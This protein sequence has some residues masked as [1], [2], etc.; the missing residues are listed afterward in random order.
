MEQVDQNIAR[1]F[2]TGGWDSTFRLLQL[3]L[4]QKKKVQ[5]YYLIDEDRLSTG[6]ELRTMKI[7]KKHLFEKYP[8]TKGLML[9]TVFKAVYDIQPNQDLT[10]KY[11][12]ILEHD[13]IGT[14]YEWL[15]RF[16][17]EAGIEGV[18]LGIEK[19]EQTGA[20]KVLGAFLVQSGTKEDSYYKFNEEFS[21]TDE[22]GL[23]K[24]YNFPLFNIAKIDMQNIA[25]NEGFEDLL[26]LTWFCHTPRNNRPC[27]VCTP[28]VL[29]IEEGL[30]R[31]IPLSSR[32]RYYRRDRTR[33]KQFLTKWPPISNLLAGS[34]NRK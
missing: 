14:Q 23:F 6:I 25:G 4:L 30:E 1:L 5:T 13:H 8:T 33:V 34:E 20:Y 28:C 17:S 7:I 9:P 18:E 3:L 15:A 16:C 24:F 11:N 29:A 10:K 31:R 27:G 22:Y 19:G 32:F 26:E 21:D 12:R 2:W